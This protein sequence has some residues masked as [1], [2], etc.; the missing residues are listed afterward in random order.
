MCSW[1]GRKA[2][3]YSPEVPRAFIT[4]DPGKGLREARK[5]H[6]ERLARGCPLPRAQY[7]APLEEQLDTIAPSPLGFLSTLGL[8]WPFPVA[9]ARADLGELEQT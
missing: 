4:T 6:P 8:A 7:Q 9:L 2:P 1:L 5:S 3:F